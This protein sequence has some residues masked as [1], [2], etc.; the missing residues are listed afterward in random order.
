MSYSEDTIDFLHKGD[1]VGM[2]HSLAKA[3]ENDNE[4]LLA[5]LAEYMQMM[6][7]IDE[8]HQIYDKILSNDENNSSYLLNLA[9]IAENDGNLDEALDYLYQIT[10]DD[11]NYVAALVKIAD[12]YQLD[13]DFETATDKLL[14]AE[15]L[16]DSSL[17]TFALAENYY[18]AGDFYQ[19]IQAYQKLVSEEIY[20]LTKI[21]IE[22]RIG[23]S[24]AKMGQFENAIEF[25]ENAIKFDKNP[26][27][28]YELAT[29]YMEIDEISRA[30][31]TFQ[32]LDDL[33]AQ[34]IF[35]EE[36]FAQAYEMNQEFDKARQIAELGL[37][38]NP[39]SVSLRH[40]LS[41][42]AYQQ[43][44]F[45]KAEEH[46]KKALELP[47]NHDETVFLL[48]NL[49]YNQDDFEAVVDL[50]DLLEEEHLL[51][52]WIFAESYKELEQD[53]QAEALYDEL[54]LSDLTENPDFVKDYVDFLRQTGQ[55]EKLQNFVNNNSELLT[56]ENEDFLI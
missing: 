17:V 56:D 9:E 53:S 31:E 28:Y 5:D 24:Y 2:Q 43:K 27:N 22:Q 21:S 10:S 1:L 47:E 41:R 7:F 4:D 23:D 39:N 14:E 50:V 30:I 51:A 8:S 20:A 44:N 37:S 29:L 16:S 26:E 46:L 38:K 19:A 34:F 48:A 13:G 18:A 35:Y 11:E 33:D 45:A 40:F 15:K 12:L 54:L 32:K 49:Y 6:G 3:L 25:L 42:N 52:Q 36:A 55:R